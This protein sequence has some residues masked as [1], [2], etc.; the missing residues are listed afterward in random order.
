M[1]RGGYLKAL[2]FQS[3]PLA[4]ADLPPFPTD[5][6]ASLGHGTNIGPHLHLQGEMMAIFLPANTDVDQKN[7]G[8]YPTSVRL[9]KK[10]ASHTSHLENAILR[11]MVIYR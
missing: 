4:V 9:L 6:S 11:L 7:V 1:A 3:H 2:I 8:K 10:N 5:I